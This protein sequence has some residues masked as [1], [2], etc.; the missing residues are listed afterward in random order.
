MQLHKTR[1]KEA[2][3][4][5]K[6]AIL[7]LSILLGLAGT[8]DALTWTTN[9]PLPAPKRSQ[10]VVSNGNK[11]Y[12]LGGRPDPQGA[13]RASNEVYLGTAGVGG[14]FTWT[15][16]TE[17]PTNRADG[18]AAIYNNRL[19]YFGGWDENF[20]TVNTCYYAP[21]N[22]DGT[23]GSWVTSAVT[24]PDQSAQPYADAFG[25]PN[26]TINGRLYVINGE[27]NDGTRR[28]VALYNTIQGGGDYGTWTATNEPPVGASW[29]HALATTTTATNSYLYMMGGSP[30]GST[31]AGA[32]ETVLRSTVNGD[33][34]LQAWDTITSLPARRV[35]VS[36]ALAGDKIY[37]AGGVDGNT[38][39]T[40]NTVFI[41]TI[42]PANG[43]VAWAVDSTPFPEPIGRTSMCTYSDPN[44]NVFIGSFGGGVGGGIGDTSTDKVYTAL[45]IQGNVPLAARDWMIYK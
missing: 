31:F 29:F 39:V 45:V 37:L 11:V 28:D 26:F 21:I 13:T 16:L 15:T 43:D 5:N 2:N 10:S 3:I 40:T 42:N 25:R 14:F 4:M 23:I 8:A 9:V 19:Y 34:S 35:E 44:G 20:T 32:M 18:G 41:G 30:Q 17:L 24:I 7:A 33:G 22:P 1:G 27:T 38:V 36:A 6:R 12:V